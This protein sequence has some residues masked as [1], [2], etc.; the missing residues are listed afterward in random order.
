MN[1]DISSIKSM[2]MYVQVQGSMKSMMQRLDG[3][4]REKALLTFGGPVRSAVKMVEDSH[5]KKISDPDQ[6][7]PELMPKITYYASSLDEAK[8]DEDAVL[9]RMLDSKIAENK[10]KFEDARLRSLIKFAY[11]FWSSVSGGFAWYLEKH[12]AEFDNPDF[13]DTFAGNDTMLR[14]AIDSCVP[15]FRL[16]PS[17]WLET[18]QIVKGNV[19]TASRRRCDGSELVRWDSPYDALPFV[20]NAWEGCFGEF[21]TPLVEDPAYEEWKKRA[22]D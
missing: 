15:H 1:D 18:Y 17:V 19:T 12:P 11:W 6:I 4:A 20:K 3:T 16:G 21:P 10:A 9:Q 5:N 7:P 13:E 22:C 2:R 8:R 14:D